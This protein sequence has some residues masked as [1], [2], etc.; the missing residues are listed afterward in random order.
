M[1]PHHVHA[2]DIPAAHMQQQ[3]QHHH[4]HHCTYLPGHFG[5]Q[6][7]LSAPGDVCFPARPLLLKAPEAA[8]GPR[9]SS[10]PARHVLTRASVPK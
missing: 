6:A 8:S 9:A 5:A 7:P 3:Q 1:H 4:H 10:A 2:A